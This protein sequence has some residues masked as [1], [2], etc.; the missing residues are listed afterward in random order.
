MSTRKSL[1]FLCLLLLPVS[2]INAKNKKKQLLPEIVLRAERV[3]VVIPP[4]AVEGVTDPMANRTARDEVERAIRKWGRFNL[5]LDVNTADLIIA[6]RKGNKSGPIISHSPVDDRP[7]TTLPSGGDARVGGL[8]GHP[9]L[10]EP[11]P[12]GGG[13]RGPQ[14]GSQIVSSDDAFEVYLGGGEYPLDSS[15]IWR[16][17][18]KSALSAPQVAAVEEFRKAIE[19]SEKQRQQKP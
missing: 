16:Y 3:L 19:D 10:T 7:V 15:P 6:V 18:A 9:P 1:V 13:N 4:D 14:L 5:V 2:Q 17:V 12:G 8:P 11:L